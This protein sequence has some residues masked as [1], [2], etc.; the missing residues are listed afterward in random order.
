MVASVATPARAPVLKKMTLRDSTVSE[1]SETRLVS[2]KHACQ[3][4]VDMPPVAG[5]APDTGG[6]KQARTTTAHLDRQP[7][8]L[9]LT[10]P[11]TLTHRLTLTLTLTLTHFLWCPGQDDD[12]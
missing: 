9:T 6:M 12:D 11:L 10:L 1:L 4:Q 5:W 7:K 8:A 3:R 2:D